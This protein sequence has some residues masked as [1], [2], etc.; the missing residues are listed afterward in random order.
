MKNQQNCVVASNPRLIN[1]SCNLPY[2]K[3]GWK[4]PSKRAHLPMAPVRKAPLT[5]IP[6]SFPST[7]GSVNVP[8]IKV[9]LSPGFQ[10]KISVSDS[11]FS[12]NLTENL[13]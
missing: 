8:Q 2:T 7:Q 9:T 12:I 3:L 13:R 10:V 4:I 1:N 11:R 5:I 6:H